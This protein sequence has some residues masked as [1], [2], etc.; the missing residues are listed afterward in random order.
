VLKGK[1]GLFNFLWKKQK[2]RNSQG[3]Q[4]VDQPLENKR[5]IEKITS[6]IEN[7]RARVN[8]VNI[9]LKKHDDELTEHRKLIGQ[10]SEQFENLEEK[11]N[12]V[13][14]APATD[15][16]VPAVRPVQIPHTSTTLGP[17]KG[18]S[19]QKFDINR[20]SQQQKRIL[21]VFFQNQDMTLSYMDIGRILNKSPLTIK[22]QMRE[23][24]LKADL[25]DRSI[26]EQSRHRF[27]LKKD[28]KIEKYLNVG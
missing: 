17:T 28:L 19:A 15:N 14:T 5:A 12:A 10:H 25:F 26:G 11:V 6:D 27:K 16:T 9:A 7:L 24:R 8:T 13:Q 23:I 2:V 1:M 4:S 18:E 20:F 22:N 3:E 21:A